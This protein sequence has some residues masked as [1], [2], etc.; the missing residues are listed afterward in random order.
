MN[1]YLNGE[2]MEK[3]NKKELETKFE[4]MEDG[5][6]CYQHR[7]TRF[8]ITEHFKEDGKTATELITEMLIRKVSLDE[9]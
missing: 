7:K 4:I 1:L 5:R 3:D 8:I 6:I 2:N 9:L